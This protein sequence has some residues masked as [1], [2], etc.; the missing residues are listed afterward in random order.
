[1]DIFCLAGSA[2]QAQQSIHLAEGLNPLAL[3]EYPADTRGGGAPAMESR[4]ST[5]ATS[6]FGVRISLEAH[7]LLSCPCSA[8]TA[9]KPTTY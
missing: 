6:G 2:K 4:L 7:N 5:L 8:D 9:L 3:P 1:M